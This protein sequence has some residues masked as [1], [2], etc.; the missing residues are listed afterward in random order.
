MENTFNGTYIRFVDDGTT[1]SGK[2]RVFRVESTEQGSVLG[3]VKWFGRWRKYSFFAN[4]DTVYE[5]T[6]LREIAIFC[7]SATELHRQAR[8]SRPATTPP[9]IIDALR[10]HSF[11]FANEIELQ[12]GIARALDAADIA[13]EREAVLNDTDRIDFLVGDV[14]IEVKTKANTNPVI[15]QLHRYAQ[16]PSIASLL[17]VTA[18]MRLAT[19]LPTMLNGKNV[20][21]LCLA[22]DGL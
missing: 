17:V 16:V 14:G 8:Q 11:A 7:E 15:R 19:A 22:G 20:Y 3:L 9:V 2:T 4:P 12:A 18:S 6:C 13:F 1:P 5:P 10:R 21:Y